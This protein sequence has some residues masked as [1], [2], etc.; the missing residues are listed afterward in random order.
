MLKCSRSSQ[1]NGEP[2]P[3]LKTESPYI[4]IF[5]SNQV[6]SGLNLPGQNILFNHVL[7]PF[8]FFSIIADFSLSV[9]CLSQLMFVVSGLE[10]SETGN[11]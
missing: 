1:L 7:S 3:S 11:A 6:I 4:N 2:N 10:G 5:S 8:F 9:I